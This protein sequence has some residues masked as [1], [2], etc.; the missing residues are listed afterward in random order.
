LKLRQPNNMMPSNPRLYDRSAEAPSVLSGKAAALRQRDA[1]LQA[2]KALVGELAHSFNNALAPIAGYT[3]LLGED[4][5]PGTRPEQYLS[6]LQASLR[7]TGGLIESILE[8]THPE[9]HF[10]PKAVDVSALL[11]RGTEAWKKALPET[12]RVSVE[13]SVV[14]CTLWLDEGQWTRAIGHLLQNA[15]LA[16]NEGGTVN[17]RLAEREL[18]SRAA[19]ELDLAQT[20]VYELKVEDNGCGMSPEVLEHACDPLYTT[21][22]RKPLAGLGLTLVHSVVQLQGGRLELESA[23]EG[24][25]TVTLWLPAADS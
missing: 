2:M 15:E 23:D 16:L 13:V 25:T 3:A 19:A 9:R 14:P 24:G 1:R 18:A 4:A 20:R 5:Q 7:K 8:A 17:V 6:K 10:L 12:A 22:P 21:R 11:R